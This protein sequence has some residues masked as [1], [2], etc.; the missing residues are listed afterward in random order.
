MA[1]LGDAVM[2]TVFGERP[3]DGKSDCESVRALPRLDEVVR[4]IFPTLGL[5]LN[6]TV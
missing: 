5:H 2:I 3:H 6:D 1:E 4:V